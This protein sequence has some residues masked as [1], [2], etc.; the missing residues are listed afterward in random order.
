MS[1]YLLYAF[2]TYSNS[3]YLQ[4]STILLCSTALTIL[5][6]LKK[7][8]LYIGNKIT[9]LIRV[10]GSFDHHI[11]G[12][13]PDK[14]VLRVLGRMLEILE[15]VQVAQIVVRLVIAGFGGRVRTGF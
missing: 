15:P 2:D 1:I 12:P 9:T 14:V 10:A 4:I 7:P 8:I 3:T 6:I 11:D 5:C 13:E